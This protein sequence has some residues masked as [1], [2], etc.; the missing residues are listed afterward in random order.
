[1]FIFAYK[2]LCLYL[3]GHIMYCISSVSLSI[4]LCVHL[5]DEHCCEGYVSAIKAVHHT[6]IEF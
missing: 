4:Q 5:V 6:V 2:L 3:G 1:M